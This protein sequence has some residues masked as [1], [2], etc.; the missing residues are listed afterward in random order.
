MSNRVHAPRRS[1]RIA[2]QMLEVIQNVLRR[3]QDELHDVDLEDSDYEPSEDEEEEKP[4]A[5]IEPTTTKV[6]FKKHEHAGD[7]PICLEPMKFRQH[8][9]Q[10][11]CGHKFHRKCVMSWLDRDTSLRC[12]TCRTPTIAPASQQRR[13]RRLIIIDDESD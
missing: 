5:L 9:L 10:L 2:P 4:D 6:V 3:L 8:G 11:L 1:R 12:P 7:C 13:S